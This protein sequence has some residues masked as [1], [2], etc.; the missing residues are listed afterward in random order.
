MR[1]PQILLQLLPTHSDCTCNCT[2]NLSD[3][4]LLLFCLPLLSLLLI[5]LLT[6]LTPRLNRCMLICDVTS[7]LSFVSLRFNIWSWNQIKQAKMNRKRINYVYMNSVDEHVLWQLMKTLQKHQAI[8]PLGACF[9]PAT[10]TN[11]HTRTH[12][13]THTHA[14]IRTRTHAHV[15]AR[16]Y[17]EKR[18]QNPLKTHR[19]WAG[20]R[21]SPF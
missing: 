13:H 16:A 2:T 19:Y 5:L 6:L 1:R 17:V 10:H 3:A 11:T 4:P 9:S 7:W 20:D 21:P 18:R 8:P 14:Y 15:R 12:T